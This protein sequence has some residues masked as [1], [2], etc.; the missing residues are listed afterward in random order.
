MSLSNC[1]ITRWCVSYFLSR[2]FPTWTCKNTLKTINKNKQK[3]LRRLKLKTVE[4][5]GTKPFMYQYH[6]S[7]CQCCS[8]KFPSRN[9]RLKGTNT[10]SENF[11]EY[12]ETKDHLQIDS[13]VIT[14]KFYM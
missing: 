4:T 10:N 13:A 6:N 1:F 9:K 7:S 8:L 12:K 2:G 11:R 5:F 3:G 14:F